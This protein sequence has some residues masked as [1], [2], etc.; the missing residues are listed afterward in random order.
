MFGLLEWENPTILF[1]EFGLSILVLIGIMFVV[2][3]VNRAS[4]PDAYRRQRE[5][6][7]IPYE[8][9]TNIG[10]DEGQQDDQQKG[11]AR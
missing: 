1:L 3:R 6:S 8:A 7:E 4:T 10:P 2:R 5:L 9:G 11:V